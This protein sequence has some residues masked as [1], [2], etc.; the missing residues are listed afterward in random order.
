MEEAD[1]DKD[2]VLTLEE[3]MHA[4]ELMNKVFEDVAPKTGE[5]LSVNGNDLPD[6]FDN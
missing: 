6:D 4:H 5:G 2:G 1:S 3:F